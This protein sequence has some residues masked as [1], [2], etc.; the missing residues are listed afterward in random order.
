MSLSFPNNPLK[1]APKNRNHFI[2]ENGISIDSMF[3]SGNVGSANLA[4]SHPCII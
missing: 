4:S 1:S 3:P 2:L